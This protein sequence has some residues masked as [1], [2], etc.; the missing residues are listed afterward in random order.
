[1]TE[2]KRTFTREDIIDK[3]VFK[4]K[5]TRKKGIAFLEEVLELLTSSLADKK[6][7]KI[8]NFGTLN[9]IQKRKR[10]GRNP[11]TGENFEITPRNVISFKYSKCLIFK[12]N[13][14]NYF[15]K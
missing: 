4:E 3:L 12:I 15:V 5:L 2:K 10:M 7:F 1:M 14:N 8:P 9:V 11:K 13:K 6:T